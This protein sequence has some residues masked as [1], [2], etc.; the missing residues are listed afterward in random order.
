[1]TQFLIWSVSPELTW[2]E[3]ACLRHRLISRV[4][5]SAVPFHVLIPTNGF[6]TTRSSPAHK[7]NGVPSVCQRVLVPAC[8]RGWTAVVLPVWRWDLYMPATAIRKGTRLALIL[9]GEIFITYTL[10]A[11]QENVFPALLPKRTCIAPWIRSSSKTKHPHKRPERDQP[12]FHAPS[13]TWKAPVMALTLYRR[14]H[15]QVET[16]HSFSSWTLL[17]ITWLFTHK[18]TCDKFLSQK[19]T[20]PLSCCA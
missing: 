10:Q 5:N 17:S 3:G 6:R 2:G 13:E 9:S 7:H 14:F 15:S 12:T 11:I 19:A 18:K 16:Y 1:M 4:E 8:C 20:V